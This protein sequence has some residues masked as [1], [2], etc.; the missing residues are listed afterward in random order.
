LE[1]V[2]AWKVADANF[3]EAEKTS[4]RSLVRQQARGEDTAEDTA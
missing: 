2:V 4:M 3:G 1:H